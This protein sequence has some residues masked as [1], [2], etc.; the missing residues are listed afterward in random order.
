M[1][2]RLAYLRG[3]PA[4][5]AAGSMIVDVTVGI[6]TQLVFMLLGL[7]LLLIRSSKL[8]GLA[9]TWSALAVISIFVLL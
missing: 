8:I 3:V 9:I 6:V 1:C 4:P 5:A 7:A 2:A